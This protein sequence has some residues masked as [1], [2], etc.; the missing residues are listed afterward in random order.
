MQGSAMARR[1][2]PSGTVT[3]LL[4]DVVGSTRLWETQPRI[5]PEALG[6]HDDMVRSAVEHAG[7]VLLKARGEGDSTFSVF[8]RA[9]DAAKAALALCDSLNAAPWPDGCRITTRIAL[10]S[11]EAI[12]RDGDYYG[13]TVNRAAR[14]RGVAEAGQVLLSETTANLIGD[15]LPPGSGLVDLGLR[16]LR[17]LERPEHVHL[18][19]P[20][21]EMV[22]TTTAATPA[23]PVFI[24]LPARLD[25]EPD[26][27]F[28]GRAE[29]LDRLRTLLK[30][31]DEG[32]LRV[33]LISGEAGIGKTRLATELAR[34][35][36]QSGLIVLYGR[37]E[38]ELGFAYQ[39]WSESLTHLVTYAPAPLLA[40]HAG[41]HGG[42]L[43]RLVPQLKA[44]VTALP[45]PTQSDPDTERYL[46]FGA[47]IGLLTAAADET[48]VVLVLDD[49]HWADKST[50][51]L[52]K[53][54]TSSAPRARVLVVGTY[55]DTDLSAT[56]P[57]AGILADL[58]REPS[59]ER[60]ALAG[61]GTDELV[62]MLETLTGQELD[63][64]GV[65]LAH[66]L[67]R[68]TDG[69]PFFVMEIL[70][71][72]AESGLAY[73]RDD[74]RWAIVSSPGEL[75]IPQSVRE[76]VSQRVRRLGE[77]TERV[78]GLGAVIGRD[79]DLDILTEIA[80][81][82]TE[83]LVDLLEGAVDSGIVVEVPGS[84]GRYSFTHALVEHALYEDLSLVRR[85]RVHLHI[86]EALESAGAN[87]MEELAHHWSQATRPVD[88]SKA[89]HYA[90]MAADGAMSLLAPDDAIRWYRRALELLNQQ[91]QPDVHNR[92]EL[93]IGLG[94]AQRQAGDA[95]FRET[96]L[97]AARLAGEH[98]FTD[99]LVRAALAN[100]RGQV[101]TVFEVDTER[102][103]VLSAALEALLPGDSAERAEL[104]ALS[105]AEVSLELDDA[106]YRPRV[107]EAMEM[108]RRV[109]DR[110]SLA[111]VLHLCHTSMLVPDRLQERLAITS[112]MSAMALE[113]GDPSLRWQAAFD[114]VLSLTEAGDAEEMER[115][116]AVARSLSEEI[117]DPALRYF[118]A[119]LLG[120]RALTAGRLG[121]AE[122]LAE[123]ILAIGTASGQPDTLTLY[124]SVL[125]SARREQG[126]LDEVI[127][128]L[129]GM[130]KANPDMAIVRAN[131]AVMYIELGR[132]EAAASL[133]ELD[134]K[135]QFAAF[136][137]N[138]GGWLLA[139]CMYSEVCAYLGDDK[140]ARVLF[141]KVG[142]FAGHI[143]TG[144][145][146]DV[147]SCHRYVGLLAKAMGD[148]ALAERHLAEGTAT[149]D[150]I[151]APLWAARN[152]L[153]WG[154]MLLTRSAPGD[155]DKA[156]LLGSE[157]LE[158]AR[159][160][161][162]KLLERR[163]ERLVE[164]CTKR[165]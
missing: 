87:R 91:P 158:V 129:V 86:A 155:D 45:P 150:R 70:R 154:D 20:A 37:C 10:H 46:L 64:D 36:H 104:L 148:L 63:A 165:S 50:L 71:H 81:T 61:L 97:Q 53:H 55:R 14:L 99:Q 89:V 101:S 35:C 17:D 5:M 147:G 106:D 9:T 62:G 141:D 84:P 136:K 3:F 153:D 109:G 33:A 124:G 125:L 121:E 143:A 92:I 43:S 98:G 77:Q 78:L 110:A 160:H 157:A 123:E 6:V 73:Q 56:H 54:M 82:D 75:G 29:H 149:N 16:E 22:P 83:Q 12:E 30:E 137:Y 72:L 90:Q 15:H 39:P 128:L 69:N 102:L 131:L 26:V 156:R 13:R 58:R 8:Q 93:A 66:A 140:A 100:S 146:F 80:G 94:R 67:G 159:R 42:E 138:S 117:N 38:E 49:L 44:K 34:A 151:G 65:G 161:G 112:E 23:E 25:Y 95:G 164:G 132:P 40:A 126:R 103:D 59:V 107:D 152:R 116:L 122:A 113:L 118:T 41:I 51:L 96:L 79:F 108:A 115:E 76:V 19:V 145:Q 105:V 24:P 4:T 74:G 114:R 47:A 139:L 85:Q 162:S 27:G 21:A 31:V 133:F 120:A 57:L 127:E 11:G 2:L 32:R 18:L 135:D 28:F 68:E 60:V 144:G 142:R 130:Q 163:A 111:R 48:G 134:A 1:D 7:G 88:T 119:T 52:L